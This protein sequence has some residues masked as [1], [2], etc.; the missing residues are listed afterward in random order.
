MPTSQSID[1]VIHILNNPNKVSLNQGMVCAPIAPGSG[2][3]TGV[4][5]QNVMGQ[6]FIRQ[7]IVR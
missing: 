4:V 5:R 6:N 2:Q 1:L 3:Q 7:N